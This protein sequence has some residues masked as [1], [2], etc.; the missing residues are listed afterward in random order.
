MAFW[1]HRGLAVNDNTQR[2]N[3]NQ[4]IEVQYDNVNMQRTNVTKSIQNA[5]VELA[6][7]RPMLY[8]AFSSYYY[9]HYNEVIFTLSQSGGLRKQPTPGGVPVNMISPGSSV[10]DLERGEESEW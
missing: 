2:A 7:A 10:M 6:F 3:I 8:I 1:S 9:C 4:L 5:Y